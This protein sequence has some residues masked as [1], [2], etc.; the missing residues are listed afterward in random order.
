MKKVLQGASALAAIIVAAPVAAHA[1]DGWYG[2][3]DVGYSFDGNVKF[4]SAAAPNR[5]N[6]DADHKYDWTEHLGL[7]YAFHDGLRLEAEAGHR[8]NKLKAFAN[9]TGSLIDGDSRVWSGMVNAFWDFNKGGAI[10]PYLGVGV[11]GA[12]VHVKASSLGNFDNVDDTQTKLAYQGM[13]GLAFVLSPQLMADFGYR[14]FTV[15]NIDMDG[16]TNGT[17]L[18]AQG[19]GIDYDQHAVTAGLRYQFA[20]PAPPP[21]PPPPPVV[22]APAPQVCPAQ[23]FKVYFEWDRSNLNAS[24][25]DTINAAAARAKACNVSTVH[26]VGYTDTSGSAKYNLGLSNRRAAV[27]RDA[28]VGAGIPAALVSTEGQGETN[29]DKPTK[30]GVREPLNRR[31]AV[32]ISFQ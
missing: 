11:G 28:L 24:A 5:L 9:S 29:L 30:D 23:D 27:V 26:V 19:F 10:Q 7:G 25:V 32:T 6:G 16:T 3:A 21:A 31:T 18:T 20:P 13:L 1:T 15:P 4:G 12:Q 22:A 17:R 8:F 2:R 14:Y